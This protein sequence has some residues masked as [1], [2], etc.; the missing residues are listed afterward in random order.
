MRVRSA[1]PRSAPG[2]LPALLVLLVMTAVTGLLASCSRGQPPPGEAPPSLHP[3]PSPSQEPPPI[4]SA[5]GLPGRV[6]GLDLA[7]TSS[8]FALLAD[9]PPSPAGEGGCAYHVAVLVSAA[10][11]EIRDAPL[12]AG[13]PRGLGAVIEAASPGHARL[14]VPG[15]FAEEDRVW[16]TADGGR[17]WQPAPP[18]PSGTVGRVPPG[19]ALTK[20]DDGAVAA[21]MPATAEL[22]TL[23]QQP[24][25]TGTGEPGLL[26]DGRHWI[27]GTDPASGLP[28]VA[29]T[30]PD[31]GGWQ[32]LAPLPV[33]EGYGQRVT[34]RGTELAAGPG[35]LYAFLT[36]PMPGL[37]TGRH[38]AG[39]L[40]IDVSD[41]GGRSWERVWTRAQ[42]ARPGSLSGVPIPAADGSLL[43]YA[44]DAI[45]VSRDGGRT[46]GVDRPGT[47]PEEP[48]LTRAGYLLRD[49]GQPG[50]YRVS[51]DGFSWRTV[52][53][54]GG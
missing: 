26:P 33:P 14:T 12:P 15:G 3:V 6:I 36:G 34:P 51:A 23:A 31:G 24:P 43:V 27:A 2:R 52:V 19:A 44:Q 25:L 35:G 10:A 7:D 29:V 49:L 32:P 45:Y 21:L 9:C 54:A 40:A 38:G 47:P 5:S 39:L 13:D 28:A 4:P 41:D 42:D 46:F 11:W 48:S 20:T 37:T 22:R 53:L 18:G 17:T 1:V 30:A 8:G 16:V 50:Y